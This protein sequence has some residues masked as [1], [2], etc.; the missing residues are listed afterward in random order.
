VK[1][2]LKAKLKSVVLTVFT[3]SPSYFSDFIQNPAP[4]A[5]KTTKE[6]VLGWSDRYGFRGNEVGSLQPN[7]V[8]WPR[9]K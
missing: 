9:P 3:C 4:H 7:T 5:G 1:K 6:I 2:L 8:F